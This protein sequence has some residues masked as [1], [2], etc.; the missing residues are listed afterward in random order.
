MGKETNTSRVVIQIQLEINSNMSGKPLIHSLSDLSAVC[1]AYHRQQRVLT[2]PI[3]AHCLDG[4]GRTASFILMVAAASEIDIA[5]GANKDEV[6]EQASSSIKDSFKIFPDL[7]KMAALMAQQRKGI[8]RE[9]HH[10][11][12]AYEGMIFHSRN[13]LIRK[14]VLNASEPK[15]SDKSIRYQD[16]G[17]IE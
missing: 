16:L 5:I 3:I 1:L 8:L 15:T 4:S 6:N 12:N 13:I 11:K 14:G 2:H 17:S 10:F 7:V 9:R